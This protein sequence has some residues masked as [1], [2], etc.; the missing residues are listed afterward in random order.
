MEMAD[1][2]RSAWKAARTGARTGTVENGSEMRSNG[3]MDAGIWGRLQNH[4]SLRKVPERLP[5][6]DF[7]RLSAVSKAWHRVTLERLESKPYVVTLV[8][9]PHS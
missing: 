4:I 9:G 7:F 5:S 8:S 1:K 6:K 3:T 2:D